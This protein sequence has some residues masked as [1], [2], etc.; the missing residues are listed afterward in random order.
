M[1]LEQPIVQ[2]VTDVSLYC[3]L[4]GA[5]RRLGHRRT[6]REL[7][8]ELLCD[9]LVVQSMSLQT[10]HDRDELALIPLDTLDL[11]LGRRLALRVTGL[12]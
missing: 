3:D 9:L 10:R 11:D 4:L 12:C 5:S 1:D 2:I 8:A 6:S 7:L